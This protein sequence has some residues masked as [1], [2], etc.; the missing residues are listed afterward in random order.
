MIHAR[1]ADISTRPYRVK[2][3][4][5][6]GGFKDN[7]T[8]GLIPQRRTWAELVISQPLQKSPYSSPHICRWA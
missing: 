8:D 6:L 3:I 7:T 1:E 4:V 5:R 2:D